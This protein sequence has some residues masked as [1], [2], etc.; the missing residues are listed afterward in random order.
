MERLQRP[1][2]ASF[3]LQLAAS[4][5]RLFFLCLDLPRRRR[6]YGSALQNIL[7]WRVRYGAITLILASHGWE[8]GQIA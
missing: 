7:A 5:R 6:G 1:G 4:S 3:L 8:R 2:P